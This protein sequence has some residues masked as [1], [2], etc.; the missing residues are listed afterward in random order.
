[1][2]SDMRRWIAYA[3]RRLPAVALLTVAGA[4]AGYAAVPAQQGYTSA[5]VLL[6]GSPRATP[7]VF[8]N[9]QTQQGQELLAVTFAAM[10]DTPAVAQAAVSAAGVPR[11]AGTAMAETTATVV[12][13]TSLI[14]VAV[15]DG[16]AHVAQRLANSMAEAAVAHIAALD[17]VRTGTGPGAPTAPPLAVSQPA[18]LDLARPARP[19]RHYVA[20]GA[21]FGLVI[22]VALVLVVDY[23]ARRPGASEPEP[24][25]AP[26]PEPERDPVGA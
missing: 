17:P 4:A 11:S 19:V 5:A 24:D 1:M 9:S 13:G 21:L 18:G 8:F 3:V 23:V 20:R 25:P 22:G 7:D 2:G 15:S 12:P 14:R 10:V 16:D 26:A 6:V